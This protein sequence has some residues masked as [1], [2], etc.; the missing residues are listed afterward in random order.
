MSQEHAPH[1]GI[2]SLAKLREM[3]FA[4]RLGESWVYAPKFMQPI[5]MQETSPLKRSPLKPL[6]DIA[7]MVDG[8]TLDELHRQAKIGLQQLLYRAHTGDERA[9]LL[10]AAVVRSAVGS[11]DL[12]ST[13]QLGKLRA[14][15]EKQPRWP[16]LLSL[17]PQDIKRAKDHLRLL[18]VGEKADTP[19]HPGQH[20]D[21]RNFWTVLA[22]EALTT[23]Q[24][25]KWLVPIL[26]RH[27]VGASRERQTKKFWG[28]RVGA[29]CYHLRSDTGVIIVTDWQKQCAKLPEPISA[30]NL[31]DWWI[32]IR[33]C[34]LEHW[35]N[36]R[37]NYAEALAMIGQKEEEEWR[38]RGMARDRVKQALESLLDLQ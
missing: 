15:A 3:G 36:S 13:S 25:N 1:P 35:W 29:T 17:N 18:H 2:S 38:R 28:T 32:A 8:R 19:T 26:K 12:L 14:E 20:L 10:Y 31:K 23:C 5:I 7:A 22:F 6:A 4:Q 30:V 9:I 11:M 27:A 33:G 16:V 21:R 37:G 34:V 24:I